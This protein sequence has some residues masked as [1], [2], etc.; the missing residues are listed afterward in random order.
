[1]ERMQPPAPEQAVWHQV[2]RQ[3]FTTRLSPSLQP[4]YIILGQE[5]VEAREEVRL[6][7]DRKY[8]LAEVQTHVWKGLVRLLVADAGHHALKHSHRNG[9]ISLS[10]RGRVKTNINH[11]SAA[12]S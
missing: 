1:M 10:N 2:N 3:R 12:S 11:T 7:R 8:G 5:A 4:I 9:Q 6:V